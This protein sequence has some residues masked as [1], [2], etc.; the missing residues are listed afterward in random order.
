M[1][2]ARRRP[3]AGRA[4]PDAHRHGRPPAAAAPAAAVD[5]P[6]RN[7]AS[8]WTRWASCCSRP[9]CARSCA[10]SSAAFSISNAC[11][12]RSTL[13]TAGPR[14]LLALGRSLER[15]PALKRCFETPAAP[16]VCGRCTTRL[17]ELPD[18]AKLILEAIADEPPLDLA[19]G[20]AIRAGFHA[21]LD[22]LRDLSQ[23]G[24][25]YIAQIEA[26]ERQRT[27]IQSLKVRF[28]NVFGYYIE[29]TRANHAPG[30][31]RLRAQADAGQRRALHHA[32]AE[33]LRAQGAGRRREDP[34]RWK[35]SCSP[36]SGSA[37]PPRRSA[38]A[39]PPPPW[40]SWM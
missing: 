29:I 40:P 3:P 23:N 16:P 21:E 32:G 12:P 35:R 17:D 18:V 33:G 7:R 27:G 37:P 9:S 38:S 10:S 8:G 5:G 15:I 39:P 14:D 25:Q 1:P 2:A 24:Q 31:G 30:P 13:G 4:R 6:R 26:R 19:D 20:G 11:W 28:N 36:T 34:E 22:E